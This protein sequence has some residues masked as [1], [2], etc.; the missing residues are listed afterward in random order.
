MRNL[1]KLLN[2]EIKLNFKG[3]QTCL[4]NLF[5]FIVVFIVFAI[6]MGEQ[7]DLIY[8]IIHGTMW[9][10]VLL[11]IIFSVDQFFG[12]DFE[13]GCYDELCVLGY[14]S[15]E[16]ILSKILAIWL[17]VAL[18]LILIVPIFI[19]LLTP[20]YTSSVTLVLSLFLGSPSLVLLASVGEILLL[21]AKKN[22]VLLLL[23]IMPFYLPVLIFGVGAIDLVNQGINPNKNFFILI[24]IFFITLPLTLITGKFAIEQLNK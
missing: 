4:I 21:K 14:K 22:K 7:I 10:I 9:A 6:S 12:S 23:I 17:F 15:T 5:F 11:S 13:D 20:S 18:P 8:Q 1:F 16:I 19:K 24:G 2:R 3:F